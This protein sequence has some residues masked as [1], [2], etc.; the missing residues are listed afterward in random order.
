LYNF[1]AQERFPHYVLGII[2][3]EH[4]TCVLLAVFKERSGTMFPVAHELYRKH[5]RL[6]AHSFAFR[7]LNGRYNLT[8]QL[9]QIGNFTNNT[10][11]QNQA[12]HNKQEQDKIET[13]PLA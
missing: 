5:E 3:Y 2:F 1:T 4:F 11:T 10:Q 6:S 13:K 8:S 12:K 9:I 7:S